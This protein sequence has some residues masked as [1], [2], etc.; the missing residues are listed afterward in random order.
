MVISRQ[1][2]WIFFGQ[3]PTHARIFYIIIKTSTMPI[4]NTQKV[5]KKK[6]DS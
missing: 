5:G 1:N 2:I 3:N 6:S 4:K